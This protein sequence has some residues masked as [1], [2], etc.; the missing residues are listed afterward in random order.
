MPTQEKINEEKKSDYENF[1]K[2]A[3]GDVYKP[4]S[5]RKIARDALVEFGYEK[6]AHTNEKAV[7]ERFIKEPFEKYGETDGQSVWVFYSSY[8][9]LPDA[10]LE[11][12]R[13][14]M[15]ESQIGELEASNAFYKYAE[16]EDIS[17]EI[18]YFKKAKDKFLAKYGDI[19]INVKSWRLKQ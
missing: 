2:Q 6:Y 14:I 12:W 7:S 8:A 11:D 1:T 15:R 17:K 4:N 18:G 16:G 19:P 13:E 3:L 9:P 10:V 5:K